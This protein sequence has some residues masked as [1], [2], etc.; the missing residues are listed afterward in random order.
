MNN[1]FPYAYRMKELANENNSFMKELGKQIQREA[2][3]GNYELVTHYRLNKS[4]TEFLTN[5]RF[6]KVEVIYDQ[7]TRDFMY[8]RI[9]W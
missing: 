2:G 1:E 8:T 5:S 9:S 6:F 3:F 7:Y 4:Q